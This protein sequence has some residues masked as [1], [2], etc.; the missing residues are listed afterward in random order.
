MCIAVGKLSL[1][2]WRMV[3]VVVGVDRRL[4]AERRRPASSLARLAITSL[5]FMLL[6]VPRAGLP[7]HQRE[8]VVELAVDHL[9]GGRVDRLGE[10]GVEPALLA[11]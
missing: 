8:V 1:D 3:D 11:R 10:P 7:D 5:T 2:D 6:W 9:V 4:A